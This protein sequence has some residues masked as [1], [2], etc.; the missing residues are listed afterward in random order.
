MLNALIIFLY[1]ILNWYHARKEFAIQN[2]DEEM[3]VGVITVNNV[4]QK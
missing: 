4:E 3:A 2:R 1:H